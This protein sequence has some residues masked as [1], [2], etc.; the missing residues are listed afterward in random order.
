VNG[1]SIV[2]DASVSVNDRTILESLQGEHIFVRE[3]SERGEYLVAW[4]S[5]ANREPYR[6]TVPNGHVFV[7]GDNRDAS[8]DSRRHGFVPLVDVVGKAKQVWL[9][10]GPQGFRWYRSGLIVDAND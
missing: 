10:K 1:K 9:S 8:D 2:I 6:G 7:L 5:H 3:R 4:Q